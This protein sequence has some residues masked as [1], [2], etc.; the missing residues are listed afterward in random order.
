MPTTTKKNLYLPSTLATFTLPQ[1]SWRAALQPN[2][3]SYGRVTPSSGPSGQTMAERLL[4]ARTSIGKQTAA[5]AAK[6]AADEQARVAAAKEAAAKTPA[7]T[8]AP[9]QP[10]APTPPQQSQ[11][12]KVAQTIAQPPAAMPPLTSPPRPAQPSPLPQQVTP[13][14]QQVTPPPQ[15]VTP[16]PQTS[17]IPAAAPVAQPAPP[18]MAQQIAQTFTQTPIAK[19]TSV[20]PQTPQSDYIENGQ[21]KSGSTGQVIGS[22]AGGEVMADGTVIDP[23]GSYFMGKIKDAQPGFDYSGTLGSDGTITGYNGA[24]VV[25]PGT[26][27]QPMAAQPIAP[28]SPGRLSPTPIPIQQPQPEQPVAPPP[29]PIQQ[30]V[31]QPVQQPAP[32][33]P[34]E[35]PPMVLAPPTPDQR[36]QQIQDITNNYLTRNP[37]QTNMGGTIQDYN[38]YANYVSNLNYQP[39]PIYSAAFRMPQ[40]Y[41]D[42]L[43]GNQTNAPMSP[44]QPAPT[45][46]VAPTPD[47]ALNQIQDLG[48]I[49]HA[50]PTWGNIDWGQISANREAADAQARAQAQQP[51]QPAQP[52]APT[53]MQPQSNSLGFMVVDD[54]GNPVDAEGGEIMADGTVID[55]SGSYFMGKIAGATNDFDY[56]G[57][58]NQG[59]YFGNDSQIKYMPGQQP[60][61]D[62]SAGPVAPQP[63]PVY[64]AYAGG[65]GGPQSMP[66][67][68][69]GL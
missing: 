44:Q 47:P 4:N 32:T 24:P 6:Q 55:P 69:T 60:P 68:T 33:Q 13:P 19:E 35:P 34:V 1:A 8:P 28:I 37:Y 45:Q 48:Q 43:A 62:Q 59:Q 7:T 22:A 20:A 29:G 51:E 3:G 16:P 25:L 54:N 38:N 21:L 42:W 11:A 53:P 40:S 12:E 15:Q 10:V 5:Y 9:A 14:P 52:V 39:G 46:P 58:I 26:A 18:T 63:M 67:L 17:M 30:P 65:G 31:Q 61:A 66:A 36:Q 50:A 2:T 23:S 41:S 57:Y 64:T 56:S 49:V 27:P